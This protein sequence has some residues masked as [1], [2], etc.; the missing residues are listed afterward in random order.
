MSW[1]IASLLMFISSISFYLAVKKL[2]VLNVDKRL[3]T[4]ANYLFPTVIFFIVSL[5]QG[6]RL[7][8]PLLFI[9]S[10]MVLRVL[11]NYVGTVAGY[12]SME[13]APNAGYSLVIQKSYAIYTLFAAA[14]IY[15]SE[16]SVW[17]FL[18][19]GFILFCASLVAFSKTTKTI[20]SYRWALYAVVAMLSFGSI[21]LSSK[22]F[23]AHGIQASP[24]L[25]WTCLLTLFITIGDSYRVKL[26]VGKLSKEI[27]AYMTVLGISVSSFYFFKLNAELAAPN[28]GYVAAINAASNAV[29]TVLVAKLF[30]D[31]LSP[32]KMLAVIG[33]TIGLVLLLFT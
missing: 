22:Y 4:L 21:S 16:I 31:S 1:I 25:F 14:I 23:A 8:F 27:V 7:L 10:I 33:M 17:R 3:I 32:K 5:L 15:G 12:K 9:L 24:Q 13:E 2:Q 29:Y 19:S 30:G 11:F 18:L 6:Q 20:K 26:S 28:L